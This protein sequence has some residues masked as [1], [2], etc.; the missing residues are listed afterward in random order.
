M[1]RLVIRGGRLAGPEPTGDL[2]I[3]DG[4]IDA[5]GRVEPEPG[6]D[7]LRL[8]GE[9]V[10]PGLVNTHHHLYQW[11]TRGYAYDDGLF[12]WLT[13]LYPIWA[14]MTPDDVYTAALAGL[15][16]LALTGCTTASDHHY[17]VPGGDDTVFDRIADAA[18]VVGISAHVSRG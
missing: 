15:S 2:A 10:T 14:R 4:L 12:G 16:E 1:T 7:V 5:V 3:R 9:I 18:R 17:I 6:D 13:T 11:A 8:D